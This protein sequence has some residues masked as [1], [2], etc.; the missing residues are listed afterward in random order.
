MK[1]P[2]HM[3]TLHTPALPEMG[4][5]GLRVKLQHETKQTNKQKS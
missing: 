5:V 4:E 1:T 3:K 2:H